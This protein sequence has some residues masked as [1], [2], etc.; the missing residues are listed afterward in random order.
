MIPDRSPEELELMFQLLENDFN[1]RTHQVSD[2]DLG[3]EML[4]FVLMRERIRHG[5]ESIQQLWPTI[6]SKTVQRMTCWNNIDYKFL[7]AD[8]VLKLLVGNSGSDAVAL[9]R[10]AVQSKW[11]NF[12]KHQSAIASNSRKNALHP[13]TPLVREIVEQDPRISSN[14]LFHRL[15]NVISNMSSPSVKIFNDVFIPTESDHQ[16]VPKKNLR[17]FLIRAK[18][19]HANG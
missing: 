6:D 5:V 11:E 1:Q 7:L 16:S 19:F 10:Q 3:D 12:S 9:L 4:E 15:K 18:K 13:L 17:Q 2:E 8:R 14:A